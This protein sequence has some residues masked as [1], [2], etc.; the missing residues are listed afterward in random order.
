M[1]F[2]QPTFAYCAHW[3]YV[4]STFMGVMSLTQPEHGGSFPELQLSAEGSNRSTQFSRIEASAP[5]CLFVLMTGVTLPT[6]Y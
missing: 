6:R 2:D 1:E 5:K 4:G 3:E